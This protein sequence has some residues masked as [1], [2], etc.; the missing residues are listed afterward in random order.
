VPLC[1]LQVVFRVEC[2]LISLRQRSF[3][4]NRRTFHRNR[5]GLEDRLSFKLL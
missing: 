1:Q 5:H 4:V 3:G 2:V